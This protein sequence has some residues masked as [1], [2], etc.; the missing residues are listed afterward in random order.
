[1][2][3]HWLLQ[4]LTMFWLLKA[5][6]NILLSTDN[7]KSTLIIV[8]LR[9]EIHKNIDVYTANKDFFNGIDTINVCAERH[10][11]LKI[12]IDGQ[13]KDTNKLWQN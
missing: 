4:S 13:L 11:P 8:N 6:M 7:E 12:E 3:Y 9:T 5:V 1:M 10:N 2:L